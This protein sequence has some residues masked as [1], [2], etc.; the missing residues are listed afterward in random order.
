MDMGDICKTNAIPVK[1]RRGN[2]IHKVMS[3]V[4]HRMTVKRTKFEKH[5]WGHIV[6]KFYI[7][8]KTLQLVDFNTGLIN[9]EYKVLILQ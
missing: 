8:R 3:S 9:N 6:G 4:K 1:R 7:R 2:T 5:L